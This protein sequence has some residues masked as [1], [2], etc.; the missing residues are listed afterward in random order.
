[1]VWNRKL[2]QLPEVP[3][4]GP[5]ELWYYLYK[6]YFSYLWWHRIYTCFSHWSQTRNK[7]FFYVSQNIYIVYFFQSHFQQQNILT[8]IKKIG[9]IWTKI[10]Y[11]LPW[12]FYYCTFPFKLLFHSVCI[13]CHF[14]LS[15]GLIISF[16]DSSS[17]SRYKENFFMING[18]FPWTSIY[19]LMEICLQWSTKYGPLENIYFFREID[20]TKFLVIFSVKSR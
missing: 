12:I 14:D 2:C 9:P 11:R 7:T 18:T 10:I 19:I 4:S 6:L 8:R 17:P 1:M 15:K 13:Y 5:P 3:S 20:F 16:L